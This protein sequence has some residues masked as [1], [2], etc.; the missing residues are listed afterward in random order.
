MNRRNCK[1]IIIVFMIGLL[2]VI[3]SVSA[4]NDIDINIH[5]IGEKTQIRFANPV[6]VAGIWHYINITLESQELQE[7][8]LKLYNGSSIPNLDERDETNYYEWKYDENSQ[9]WTDLNEYGGYTYIKNDSCQKA[10]NTYSFCAGIK[11]TLPSRQFYH[12]NWTLEVYKDQERICSNAVVVEKPTAIIGTSHVA[13]IS[14]YVDP[15]TEMDAEGNDYFKVS[16]TGNIPLNVNINYGANND[17]IDVT[18][19][20]TKFSPGDTS[21]VYVTL[22]SK[23]WKPG[24]IEI[25]GP[26]VEGTI[27]S[28]SI[29]PTADIT[30]ESAPGVGSS[31]L[32]IN[33]GHANHEIVL[34]G[35]DII[36]Q[37]EKSLTMS[38]DEIKDLTAYISGN[39]EAT[40]NIWSD[41]KN[42]TILTISSGNQEVETPFTV[43]STDT[44]E[45]K[46][47]IKV[48]A[49]RENK[50]GILYYRLEIEGETQT[51]STQITIEP[52]SSQGG[53]T[54]SITTPVMAIIVII[55]IVLVI[56]Y[57]VSSYIR[58]GRR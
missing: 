39:G 37:Y 48:K 58:H 38:E 49:L 17:I 57:M 32:R 23:S 30:L 42:I 53:E 44:S 11:D 20:N 24:F 4:D 8:S 15:F 3:C 36:F 2:P 54:T 40:L 50:I 12:E 28:S 13:I 52:P 41:E 9:Q 47:I 45:Q 6:I 10:G 14:F 7:L 26:F 31:D 46:I 18:N 22:Y 5:I 34:V 27:L 55:C 33:V 19:L 43:I 29:I 21:N 16:N 51:F 1:I 35:D 25:K 56:G